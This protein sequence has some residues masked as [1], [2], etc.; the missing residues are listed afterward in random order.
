[1][2]KTK[3]AIITGK[4]PKYNNDTDGANVLIT[5]MA[6][7]LSS[8]GPVD[9]YTPIGYS[10]HAYSRKKAM[11]QLLE[12]EIFSDNVT[13]IRFP[14][15][16]LFTSEHTAPG[17]TYLDRVAISFAEADYFS[18]GLLQKYDLVQINHMAHTFGIILKDYVPKDR[19]VVFPMM[20][21]N[22]Y[23]LF[24]SVAPEYICLEQKVLQQIHHIQ[25]PSYAEQN[26]LLHDYFVSPDKVI[27]TPR[28]YDPTVFKPKYRAGVNNKTIE[29]VSGNMVRPQKGQKSF[30]GIAKEARRR[31]F[32]LKINLAGVASTS[33][34]KQYNLYSQE[35]IEEIKENDLEESFVFHGIL[36]QSELA[37]LMN[38][39][40]IAVVPSITETF[41]KFPLE[42]VVSGLPTIV[43]N[44]V[45]AFQE[46]LVNQQTGLTVPR[47][48][49]DTVDAIEQLVGNNKL[50]SHISREGINSANDFTWDNVIKEL[51]KEY[52]IRG[53]IK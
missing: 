40:H 35:L 17:S 16:K 13:I 51:L 30:I 26:V 21:G 19:V 4:D 39:S 52:K 45:P 37:E 10:G 47:T 50:Y 43:Y 22:F 42:C 25:S 9:I 31:G 32:D 36:T 20:L 3:T 18:Q 29:I 44:D 7:A 48:A 12:R 34:S 33:Y 11:S 53:I 24:T 41:G 27:V 49:E 46:F 28:G 23:K 14:V 1:M 8:K 38:K 15:T 6:V 5:N 2:N